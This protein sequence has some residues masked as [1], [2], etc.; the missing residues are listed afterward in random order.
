MNKSQQNALNRVRN[1]ILQS[2]TEKF[3]VE[4][5]SPEDVQDANDDYG[6]VFFSFYIGKV[7]DEGTALVVCREFWSGFIGKRGKVVL[8]QFPDSIKQL[9]GKTFLGFH[10]KSN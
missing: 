1:Y 10:V 8:Q 3:P 5:K 6:L 9:S 2:G 7:G 4:L